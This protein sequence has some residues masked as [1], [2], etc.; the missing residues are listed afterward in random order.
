MKNRP[1]YT[2]GALLLMVGMIIVG[3][4]AKMALSRGE[5]A[6]GAAL[7]PPTAQTNPA[8]TDTEP[9]TGAFSGQVKLNGVA[10]GV[11]STSLTL[12]AGQPDLGSVDLALQLTQTGNALN[13]FVALDKTLIFS[14]EHTLAGATPLKIGPYVNGTL[15]GATLT[16]Q[17]ERVKLELAGQQLWR[18]FQLIGTMDAT[19]ATL[20]GEYRETLWGYARQPVTM[21]GS[22]TLQRPDYS[23]AVTPPSSTPTP[24]P[25]PSGA[26]GNQQVFL[27]V[28]RR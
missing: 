15:D 23:G 13:G 28:V 22:F 26:G 27:P 14:V 3:L 25:P 24:I 21:I 10:T 8:T 16:L 18:Q 20:T 11:Y 7:L 4:V 2:V 6:R 9:I 17:S 5:V 19:G 1:F 12:P